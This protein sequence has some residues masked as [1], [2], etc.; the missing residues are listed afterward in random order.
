[1][2][3][4]TDSKNNKRV[5]PY[6]TEKDMMLTEQRSKK[7][8]K[9]AYLIDRKISGLCQ[10]EQMAIYNMI[11]AAVDAIFIRYKGVKEGTLEPT[12]P[13]DKMNLADGMAENYTFHPKPYN[14]PTIN[15]VGGYYPY[16][17]SKGLD[18]NVY[19]EPVV[20][21]CPMPPTDIPQPHESELLDDLMPAKPKSVPTPTPMYGAYV[22]DDVDY[23]ILHIPDKHGNM[24]KLKLDAMYCSIC[25]EDDE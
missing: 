23:I 24:K 3:N 9:A 5:Y 18:F 22:E 16:Q 17:S 21:P 8:S 10:E 12:R 7:I 1:M 2:N 19:T 11:D 25:D 20:V 4:Y 14:N 15:N 6:P 13:D